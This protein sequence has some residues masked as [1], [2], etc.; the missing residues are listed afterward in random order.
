MWSR[1]WLRAALIFLAASDLAVGAWAYRRVPD[2][3]C[4][5][6]GVPGYLTFAVLHL[7]F[8]ASHLARM[9][10]HDAT[11][12]VIALALDV[13]FPALILVTAGRAK[14]RV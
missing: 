11:G 7:V 3:R 9:P 13:A 14:R 12:L 4:P 8:H 2:L 5:A 1:R 6:P 10:A